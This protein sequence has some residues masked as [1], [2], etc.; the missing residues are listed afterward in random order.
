MAW[1]VDDLVRLTDLF[2]NDVALA[3]PLSFLLFVF[4][5]V[6]VAVSLCVF[7]LLTVQAVIATL[8]RN[9]IV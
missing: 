4:G 9:R 6:T 8:T 1:P 7:G 2:V 5:A 3:D